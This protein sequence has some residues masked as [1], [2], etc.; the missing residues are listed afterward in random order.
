ME[1]N[2][3]DAAGGNRR[4]TQSIFTIAAE[5]P[6]TCEILRTTSKEG[7]AKWQGTLHRFNREKEWYNW[8]YNTNYNPPIWKWVAS[9]VWTILSADLL[10]PEDATD[11]SKG[12]HPN[13]HAV[14]DMLLQRGKYSSTTSKK[15]GAHGYRI[16]VMQEFRA[17]KWPTQGKLSHTARLDGYLTAWFALAASTKNMYMPIDKPLCEIMLQAVQPEYLREFVQARIYDGLGPDLFDQPLRSEPWRKQA[18]KQLR[19]MRRLI[20]EH[21]E[22]LD[23]LNSVSTYDHCS[24]VIK[25]TGAWHTSRPACAVNGCNNLVN[26]KRRGRSYHKTCKEHAHVR[27]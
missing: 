16:S 14:T 6:P 21:T 5:A 8:Q 4:T 27:L 3:R 22:H 19:W 7:I 20:R 1:I 17:L 24:D 12:E 9:D 18:H 26:N 2:N 25:T 10:L 13:D 15:I 11:P 23:N